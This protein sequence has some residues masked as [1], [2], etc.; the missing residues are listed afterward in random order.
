MNTWH[1]LNLIPE[2]RPTLA[3]FAVLLA[4][5]FL[6]LIKTGGHL[7]TPQSPYNAISLQLAWS[8]QRAQSIVGAW[9][10]DELISEARRHL[11][12]DNVF[13]LFYTTLAA[14]G[15]VIAARAFFT[16]GTNAYDTAL[17]VAWLPWLSGLFDYV[18]NYGIYRMLGGFEGETLPRLTTSC[19]AVKFAL[20]TPLAV[21][22][23]LGAL[24][25][26]KR[27]LLG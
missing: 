26:A 7:K 8:E 18:E 12:W 3:A 9:K 21:Y 19:A 24:V 5:A 22:G 6:T 25:A 27:A 23:L 10:R 14:L 20:I 16:P 1:P 4:F 15:C 17:L 2:G 11:R 13:I